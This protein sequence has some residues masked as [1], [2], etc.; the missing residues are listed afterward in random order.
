MVSSPTDIRRRGAVLGSVGLLL[1]GCEAGRTLQPL[2]DYQSSAYRLGAG[3]LL[4]VLTFGEEQ[5]T[6]EFRVSDQGTIGL[7]LVGSVPASGKTSQ[8]L[9]SEISA[10]LV[11]G[12][13]LKSPHVTVEVVAYRP[14]FVLGEV[15]K[16]GQFPYQPGMT[17][18][19]AVA[20]AGGFTYRGVEDYGEVVRATNGVAITGRVTANSFLA[21]GDVV[22]VLER[23]F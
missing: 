8:Q 7:P 18:L 2:P 17:F 10:A 14:I 3:D 23:Y 5:L 9:E 16:P 4:R 6:G 1:A 19:T 21:P 22:R 13:F 20:V 11:K 12:D 15:A